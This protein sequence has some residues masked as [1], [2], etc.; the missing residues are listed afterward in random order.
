MNITEQQL[1]QIVP[2]NQ[3]IGQLCQTLN[4]VLPRYGIDTVNR[5]AGFLAQCGYE[6]SDFTVLHE[7]LNYSAEGL[8]Q[9]FP[10][11]F[12]S[13]TAQ[14]YAHNPEKIANHV[15]ASRM[16]NGPEASGDGYKYRGRGAIQLTGRDNY[17]QFANSIGFS[18]PDTVSYVETL[19]GAIS[20]AC[21]F[22]K[23][24]NINSACDSNDIT[25]MTKLINGGTNGLTE[26]T[27]RF[28]KAKGILI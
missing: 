14:T 2:R 7:N 6:S 27:A 21:W 4:L 25:K 10:K 20:V 5:V 26:R 8:L 24:R 15:Y 12:N 19:S 16:G 17:A 1:S 3:Q 13:S 9:V 23:V 18:I 11:Y 22:W 28:E